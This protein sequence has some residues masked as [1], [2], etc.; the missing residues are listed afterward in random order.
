[1]S[2][3]VFVRPLRSV[4]V[5]SATQHFFSSVT[6]GAIMGPIGSILTMG[7]VFGQFQDV[8]LQLPKLPLFCRFESRV[9]GAW[10]C[11]RCPICACYHYSAGGRKVCGR[12]Y[13]VMEMTSIPPDNAA[14]C[15][16]RLGFIACLPIALISLLVGLELSLSIHSFPIVPLRSGCPQSQTLPQGRA[17]LLRRRPLTG[18]T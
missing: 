14:S 2:L 17:V 15:N 1:V 18:I 7:F 8:D 12:T 4:H 9:V 13:C 3:C 11:T 16:S 10:V 5:D 6:S